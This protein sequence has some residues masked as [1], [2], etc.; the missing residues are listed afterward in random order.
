[1]PLQYYFHSE[2]QSHCSTI[3]ARL[4]LGLGLGVGP[5]YRTH[6]LPERHGVQ[7]SCRVLVYSH[8]RTLLSTLRSLLCLC[9]SASAPAPCLALPLPFRPY[10]YDPRPSPGLAC[11]PIVARHPNPKDHT[12]RTHRAP[13]KTPSTPFNHH[14]PHGT[15]PHRFAAIKTRGREG[16]SKGLRDLK[17]GTRAVCGGGTVAARRFRRHSVSVSGDRSMVRAF[18]SF[19]CG[20]SA[21]KNGDDLREGDTKYNTSFLAIPAKCR[22]TPPP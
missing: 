8:T 7:S 3:A 10:A 16:K 18:T 19:L 11:R 1:M 21:D 22:M 6:F 14:H 13:S 15:G 2:S 9:L 12:H 5:K 17:R 20:R 4:G